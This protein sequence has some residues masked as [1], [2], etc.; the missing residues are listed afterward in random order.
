MG[1]MDSG[2][3]CMPER[4]LH[5]LSSGTPKSRTISSRF[6]VVRPKPMVDSCQVRSLRGPV[7]SCTRTLGFAIGLMSL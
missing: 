3:V 4:E 2:E 7:P 6:D 5:S 1:M